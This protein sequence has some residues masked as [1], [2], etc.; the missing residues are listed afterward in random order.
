MRIPTATYVSFYFLLTGLLLRAIPGLGQSGTVF[1]DF[2]SNGTYESL[3]ASG[4][5]T[6]G[7]P[8]VAG[9]R[10]TAYT[11]A[12]SSASALTNAQ[13]QYSITGLSGPVRLEFTNLPS[14]DYDGF[15]G[16][17][18][19]TSVQ[20]T[21]AGATGVNFGMNY[22]RQYCQANPQLLVPCYVSGDAQAP[23]VSTFDALVSVPY[24]ASG[25]ATSPTHLATAGEV[26]SVWGGAYQRETA[27]F[28]T[29]AFLKRHVGL[30][31]GG[32]GG[33][34]VT[35]LSGS[36]TSSLYVNLEAA[37]FSLDLGGAALS[38]RTLPSS[39][40]T[41]STDPLAFD[42]VGKVGLGGM[43]ISDDG[44]RLYIVDLK[45]RQL[46]ILTIGNPAKP[47]ADLTAADLQSVAI[48]D[49]NCTNGVG[50]PF[51]VRVYKGK[52][53]VG[54]VCTGENLTPPTSATA[55]FDRSALKAFVYQM[56][57]ATNTFAA[58][59][60]LSF[61]LDYQKG[62]TH[63]AFPALGNHY[64]P[65][66]D[67]FTELYTGES[68]AQGIRVARPQA[69][70]SDI[71]FT[72][73]GDMVLGFMDRGGHQ[74]GYRQR[75]TDPNN[76]TVVSGQSQP[77]LYN[78][79]ISGDI[80]RA[81]FNG[82]SWVLE[83]DGTTLN[84]LAG[85]GTGNNQGPGGGEFYCKE[86]FVGFLSSQQPNAEIHQE[87][88][89][90]GLVHYP[91]H[92]QLVAGVLDPLNTWSGGFS[93]FNDLTGTDDRRYELYRTV[94]SANPADDLPQTLGKSNGLGAI[95]LLCEPAPIQIGN[96][97]WNDL[98]NN[99]VQDAGEPALAGVKVTLKGPDS[100]TIATVTTNA[101]GEYYFANS[102][103][104]DGNGFKYG[105]DLTSGTSYSLCFPTSFSS[106][107]LSSKLNLAGG[108]NADAVDSDADPAG[109]V[110]FTL[111]QAGQNNFTYD[112]AYQ[113]G[114]AN[115][116]VNTTVSRTECSTVNNAGTYTSTVVVT[117]A[118]P[119]AGTLSITER[120]LTQT[121]STTASASNSFTAV[122][123]GLVSDGQSHTVTASVPGCGS[124]TAA[125]TA[126]ASC[127]AAPTCGLS[128]TATG[129]NCNPTTGLYVLSG[130]IA[131]ANSPSSQTLTL[132]DGSYVRSLTASAGSTSLSFS[133]TTLQSDGAIHTVTVA[134][135]LTACG[136]AS[137]TYAA[138]QACLSVANNPM[139]SLE[140][141]VDQS[142]AK[143]GDVL[144][145]SVVLT[146][147]GSTSATTTVRDSVA[148]G[149]TYVTGSATVPAG[150]T[151]TA[152]Q[153]VS[154]WRVPR[155]AAGQSLTLTFQVRVDSTGILYNTATI[156]GDTASACTSIP[157]K[158][159][160]G[161]EYTF[162]LTAAPGRSKYQWFRTF[163]G[164]T[165]ELTD[166]TTNVLDISQPGEYKL[167]VDNAPGK[168]PDF[169]CCPFVVEETP[170]PSVTATVGKLATC[171]S[172]TATVAN[173]DAQI[174]LLT[175]GSGTFSYQIAQG[176]RFSAANALVS[177]TRPV[178]TGGLLTDKLA[179][180]QSYTVRVYNETNCFTDTT[181][182][183]PA[184]VCSCPPVKCVPFVI[185]KRQKSG[186]SLPIGV[187]GGR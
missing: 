101:N 37:P 109:V 161:D 8:G 153:P 21:T 103:G 114:A 24:T 98:N 162:R 53:Y 141:K 27:K 183:I 4:T 75:S 138:P 107:S 7:E 145:Y 83:S 33:I 38:T 81:G 85:C 30:G 143:P 17:A 151:F 2:N 88:F 91:G 182:V 122:F 51:G 95:R 59:P 32:L 137:T 178:P 124:A 93:W 74:T 46:R 65:W 64:D 123:N 185:Q 1:R 155:I 79:Y 12:G 50:R 55:S 177:T 40:T 111:G 63:A 54:V 181:V 146:N 174:Q 166:F 106:L 73:T 136:P 160:A 156:P 10:V 82:T 72:D 18:S 77:F 42:Q 128:V 170:V 22:P 62:Q 135:S 29:A 180:G 34:Y 19:A 28:F 119:T 142:R 14:G 67:R 41:S 68:S 132:T 69:I 150:T 80:L 94:G 148:G 157:V 31:T 126:P 165:T 131:F 140:K 47:T 15:R 164:T 78:G 116:S 171:N 99:G 87:T 13:G 168:C 6:Y 169:S 16:S 129:A 187:G 175:L 96:R 26:G 112:A 71:S 104:T 52:V 133:Y 11:T 97:V 121:F 23:A 43:D 56:D 76:T 108:P 70:L 92:N 184:T 3:P 102:S 115:C 127:S 61:P 100:T 60:V 149:S 179:G 152:G 158:V 159:C 66:V 120:G 44:S 39:A 86:N 58:S 154:L 144:T 36:P 130:K 139:L 167:S 48:P 125:Y 105:L 118:N 90:G 176:S 25:A 5:Y 134:S 84:G 163:G 117:I 9:I 35:D 49:P 186:G 20:F 57:I 113:S 172:Q 110:A 45:N 89:Q 147:N 173:Q